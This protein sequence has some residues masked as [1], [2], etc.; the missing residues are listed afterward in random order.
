M[1]VGNNPAR[2]LVV[3]TIIVNSLLV[4]AGITTFIQSNVNW[5]LPEFVIAIV[6]RSNTVDQFTPVSI[7]TLASINDH[8]EL[9][10]NGIL[11]SKLLTTKSD[12]LLA[13]ITNLIAVMSS[14][15]YAICGLALYDLVIYSTP[16]FLIVKLAL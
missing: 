8:L 16:A 7:N 14:Q 1:L 15:G 12:M 13:F 3:L 2:S 11:R 9:L 10:K 4:D 5:F 6:S